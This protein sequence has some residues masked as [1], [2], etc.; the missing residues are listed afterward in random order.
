MIRKIWQ[1][2]KIHFFEAENMTIDMLEWTEKNTFALIQ[3]Q[4]IAIKYKQFY[5]SI[6]ISHM[7]VWLIWQE[8]EKGQKRPLIQFMCCTMTNPWFLVLETALMDVV[9]LSLSLQV[10]I[11]LFEL[12]WRMASNSV[13]GKLWKSG[14]I[15]SFF[16]WFL[17]QEMESTF[18]TDSLS[19]L[20][21]YLRTLC[22]LV[23]PLL[24]NSILTA[25]K[26]E[27]SKSLWV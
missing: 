25:F 15:C 1:L 13:Q 21:L 3:L 19:L 18:F 2:A 23:Q 26:A 11:A 6:C 8:I 16:S 24:S 27:A 22:I 12:Q 20:Q 9:S 4:K 17:S 5:S 7:T 14:K 10:R